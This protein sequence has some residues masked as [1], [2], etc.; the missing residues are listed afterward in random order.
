MPEELYLAG[1]AFII[2]V[3]ILAYLGYYGVLSPVTVYN[4]KQYFGPRQYLYFN[5]RINYIKSSEIWNKVCEAMNKHFKFSVPAGIYYDPIEIVEDKDN[6]RVTFGIL[7]NP[8]EVQKIEA[9]LA[10]YP[11]YKQTTLPNVDVIYS[12]FPYRS[13]MSFMFAVKK[14]Y[15][16]LKKY[17]EQHNIEV[18]SYMELYDLSFGKSI[19]FYAFHG[20]KSN[21]YFLTE[22]Q[23]PQYKKLS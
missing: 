7:V 11:E 2:I 6:C 18:T 9:F 17:I 20:V 1:G 22:D 8:G 21:A 19:Q 14:V 4:K 12:S 10:E 13:V 3:G 16:N 15:P 5:E 23:A